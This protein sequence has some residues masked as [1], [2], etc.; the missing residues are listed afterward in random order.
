M[1][2]EASQDHDSRASEAAMY[3]SDMTAAA[4]ASVAPSERGRGIKEFFVSSVLSHHSSF[5]LL[6]SL[7]VRTL[8]SHITYRSPH[9]LHSPDTLL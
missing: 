2:R 8:H 4:A 5:K 7:K 1:R 9:H 6:S 3:A